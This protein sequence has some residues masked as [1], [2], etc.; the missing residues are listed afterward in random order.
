MRCYV[1]REVL[2]AVGPHR[3]QEVEGWETGEQ[4]ARWWSIDLP[5]WAVRNTHYKVKVERLFLTGRYTFHWLPSALSISHTLSTP[6]SRLLRMPH[7][8]KPFKILYT[9]YVSRRRKKPHTALLLP[10]LLLLLL[11]SRGTGSLHCTLLGHILVILRCP[12]DW[13]CLL[14][15][16]IVAVSSRMHNRIID[17]QLHTATHRA[18]GGACSQ[19][20]H[21]S[22]AL[23]TCR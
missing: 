4:S 10:L 19:Q 21:C 15:V 9:T 18:L 16:M 5:L 6:Q 8:N 1:E 22:P 23:V 13:L 17:T 2:L 7:S 3:R 20:A 12:D 14:R 11:G